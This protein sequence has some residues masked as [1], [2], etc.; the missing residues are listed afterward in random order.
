MAKLLAFLATVLPGLA[1]WA[2]ASRAHLSEALQVL[3]L[4][5]VVAGVFLLWGLAITLLVGGV[6]AVGLGVLFER[7][8]G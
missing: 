6:L 5:A 2:A 7:E 4:A 3:G 1:K 8:A